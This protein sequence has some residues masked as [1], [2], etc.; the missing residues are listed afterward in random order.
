M[1]SQND[2]LEYIR[3]ENNTGNRLK[4]YSILTKFPD[5][6]P[7]LRKM[8]RAG[9]LE[10]RRDYESNGPGQREGFRWYEITARG[11]DLMETARKCGENLREKIDNGLK[12]DALATELEEN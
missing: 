5:A 3:F 4:D 2:I 6:K 7:V 8:V 9:I 11:L 1:V 10:S 12:R